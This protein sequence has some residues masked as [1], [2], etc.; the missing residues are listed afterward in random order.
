MTSRN[1][2][3][4]Y[5]TEQIRQKADGFRSNYFSSSSIPLDIISI[6]EFDLG[7]DIRPEKGLRE[8]GDTDA[9]L[10][11]NLDVIYVDQD[12]YMDRRY[13]NR[14]R[15][16]LAHELG[17]RVLHGDYLKGRIKSIE[18][19]YQFYA[20]VT[21]EEYSFFEWH[22]NEFAGRL[23]V[24]SKDLIDETQKLIDQNLDALL[25]L[26][27]DLGVVFEQISPR[28]AP[29]FG[30]SDEVIQKRL[31]KEKVADVIKFAK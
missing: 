14:L 6:V 19:V 5:T 18:L 3:P 10:A 9:L 29:L 16:S 2:L 8:Q 23:L 28:L 26:G 11:A 30:V 15:F 22:A 24:P 20:S 12:R 21:E 27:V 31:T 13:D 17:H 4:R 7:I 1:S 25:K